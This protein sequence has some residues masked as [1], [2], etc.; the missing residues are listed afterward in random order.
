MTIEIL[1]FNTRE[2]VNA[3]KKNRHGEWCSLHTDLIDGKI[4]VTFVKGTDDP[5][6]SKEQAQINLKFQKLQELIT[7]LKDNTINLE[8]IKEL[9][10]ME[11]GI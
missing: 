7:K 5:A 4:R 9:M 1:T 8:E 6:N 11:R 10:R 2:D 3:E